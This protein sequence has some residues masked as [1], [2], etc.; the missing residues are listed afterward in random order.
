MERAKRGETWQK[1]AKSS[2][3]DGEV[4]LVEEFGKVGEELSGVRS[5]FG[6][7]LRHVGLEVAKQVLDQLPAIFTLLDLG[8]VG[9][10]EIGGRNPEGIV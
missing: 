8:N 5:V 1:L 10:Q 3:R 2:W 9:I 6:G 4:R 7:T